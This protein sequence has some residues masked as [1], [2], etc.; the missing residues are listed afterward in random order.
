MSCNVCMYV[1][2]DGCMYACMY[3]CTYVCTYVRM[4]VLYM[5]VDMDRMLAAML[6]LTLPS[7][8]A[9]EQERFMAAWFC[10]SSLFGS[11]L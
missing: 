4:Y 2:M 6:D 7:P 8:S 3:V 10:I 1:W 5:C 9:N 11:D